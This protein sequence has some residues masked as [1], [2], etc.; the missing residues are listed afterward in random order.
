MLFTTGTAYFMFVN[1]ENQVYS[2]SLVNRENSAQNKAN[3]IF[4]VTP[5]TSTADTLGFTVQNTGNIP[6]TAVAL[7]LMDSNH[8]VLG[9]YNATSKQLTS[10]TL[11]YTINTGVTSPLIDTA[12]PYVKGDNYLMEVITQR[13]STQT[14][15][16]PPNL[17]D[18]VKQAQASGSLTVDMST[19]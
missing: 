17:P 13:G 4:T 15:A 2:Q 1:G 19:F 14:V 7:L 9:L 11:P 3:E 16:Y 6:I 18:Y 10:P 5:T 12:Y 8:N